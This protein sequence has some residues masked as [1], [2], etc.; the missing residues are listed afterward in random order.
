MF[1]INSVD[2]DTISLNALEIF[3]SCIDSVNIDSIKY[4]RNPYVL[5]QIDSINIYS[6]W[7]LW[8]EMCGY[9]LYQ[10]YWYR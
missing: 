4:I 7:K 3:M 9:A 1:C 10:Q 6:I 5:Y 2:I 8:A